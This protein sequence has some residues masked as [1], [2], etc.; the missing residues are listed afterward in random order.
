MTDNAAFR[1]FVE[2][3]GAVLLHAAR[4]LTGDHHRGED[5]VQTALTRLYLKWDGVDAP[6]AYTRKALVTAHID[7]T[8]RRWWGERPTEVL[9]EVA[10]AAATDVEERDELRRLLSGLAPRERA[11][12]V[13]R[14]YCDLSEQDTAATLGMP[15]GTVKST[16]S[17]ALSRLRVEAGVGGAR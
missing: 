4:L 17:R 3:N 9:P 5:L 2:A 6:L 13:L 1:A 14:Y 16:C 15:V 8:R 12:I 7:S 10:S 11:V